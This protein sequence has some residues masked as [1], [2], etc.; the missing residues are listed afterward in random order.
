MKYFFGLF[1]FGKISIKLSIPF[2]LALAEILL[3]ISSKYFPTYSNICQGGLER[4]RKSSQLMD[5]YASSLGEIFLVIIPFIK[6]CSGDSSKKKKAN[7]N[8][9][10]CRVFFQFFFICMIFLVIFILMSISYAIS[11]MK[12]FQ[13]PINNGLFAK[14]SIEIIYIILITRILLKYKYF[15]HHIISLLMIIILSASIDAVCGHFSQEIGPVFTFITTNFILILLEAISLIFKKYLLEKYFYSPWKISTVSG[16]FKFLICF[17]VM[18]IILITG[19]MPDFQ[20]Y[21]TSLS[22]GIIIGKFITDLIINFFINL[23]VY[24][25]LINFS[26]NY[27]VISANLT[28]IISVYLYDETDNKYIC[29]ILFILEFFFV[30]VNLEIIILNFC[31]FEKNTAKFIN[32]R[33]EEE[34]N[35]GNGNEEDDLYEISPGYLIGKENMSNLSS[36]SNNSNVELYLI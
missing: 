35:M 11:K 27:Y 28:N 12:S 14:Q 6:C 5:S 25:T 23:G 20:D 16:I 10:K 30:L 21:M 4:C 17:V 1:S 36:I 26:P 29:I 33:S 19:I 31:G 22:P 8:I 34:M 32:L 24:L 13:V 2:L 9:S 18:I 15:I 7:I 3:K